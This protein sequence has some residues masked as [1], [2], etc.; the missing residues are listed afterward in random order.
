MRPEDTLLLSVFFLL[1]TLLYLLG[2]LIPACNRTKGGYL[3]VTMG[4]FAAAVIIGLLW[5]TA[6]AGPL[7]RNWGLGGTYLWMLICPAV[8]LLCGTAVTLF[9]HRRKENKE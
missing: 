7:S 1:F 5:Y 8:Y 9:N 2:S 4:C 3:R 6:F